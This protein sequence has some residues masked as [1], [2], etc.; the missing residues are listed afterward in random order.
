MVNQTVS[1]LGSIDVLFCNAGIV[2]NLVK[3]HEQSIEDW[4]RVIA[5][6]LTGTFL[7]MRTVLPIMLKK[8]RGSIISTA[9]VAGVMC[10]ITPDSAP[11]GATKA[12]IMML[13][14]H[15]AVAYAK[16]GIRINAIAPGLHSTRPLLWPSEVME[17][18][19][20]MMS[21]FIP[22]GRPAAPGEIKGL[23]VYLA[24][25]ASSYITG[26]TFITDGGLSA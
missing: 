3:L 25:D 17:D 21:K 24:S 10:G 16:D 19:E 22:M 13:T 6:N 5:V 18:M 8:K 12:G 23:A 20:K 11:Y 2:N 4:N 7:C 26:Q 15:A 9:S 1:E 14:R